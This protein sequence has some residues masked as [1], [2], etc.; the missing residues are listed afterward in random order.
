MPRKKSKKVESRPYAY[1]LAVRGGNDGYAS[2]RVWEQK[3]GG[4]EYDL[5]WFQREP[6][7]IRVSRMVDKGDYW[8]NNWDNSQHGT[9]STWEE[10]DVIDFSHMP[11]WSLYRVMETYAVEKFGV[12]DIRPL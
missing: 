7:I 1:P 10:I 3:A 8:F 6:E 4:E 9:P 12:V 2:L 5:Q 11:P